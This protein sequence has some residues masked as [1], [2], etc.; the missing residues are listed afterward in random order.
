[1]NDDEIL[2]KHNFYKKEI[3]ESLEIVK[4]YI[5]NNKIYIT[6][7]MA[8]DLALRA[9]NTS[10]YNDFT[11]PDYD[12]ISDKNYEVS[13][14]LTEILCKL[15][16]PDVSMMPAIHPT[17]IK[18]KVCDYT[19]FDCTYLP[20]TLIQKIPTLK[21]NNMVIIHPTFIKIAQ[22]K[23]MS[24]LFSVT[25]EGYNIFY[26]LKKDYTRNALLNKHYP[27]KLLSKEIN[28][29]SYIHKL[30]LKLLES[31]NQSIK[32]YQKDKLLYASERFNDEQIIKYMK[33]QDSY[34]NTENSI[35]LGPYLSYLA[36]MKELHIKDNELIF[37]SYK[38]IAP[39]LIST[40]AEHI[41]K[42][43][44]LLNIKPDH[45]NK[46]GDFIPESSKYGDI[47]KVY[48]L[49][50]E[51]LSCNITRIND[52]NLLLCSPCYCLCIFLYYYMMKNDD[53]YLIM[54]N[55]MLSLLNSDLEQS[56]SLSTFGLSSYNEIEEFQIK[57][58]KN[59]TSPL[60]QP[61]RMFTS[62]PNCSNDKLFDYTTSYLY[63]IDGSLILS[64]ENNI[65]GGLS[66][67]NSVLPEY[68]KYSDNELIRFNSKERNW[69]S[70]NKD[71]HINTTKNHKDYP[72]KTNP[73]IEIYRKENYDKFKHGCIFGL[74][75]KYDI[76][77]KEK[78]NL[79][80]TW[81]W[82]QQISQ[83]EV[84]DPIIPYIIHSNNIDLIT[85]FEQYNIP[86]N[87]VVGLLDAMA[88][89]SLVVCKDLN[90]YV[91]DHIKDTK[92][93]IKA[94]HKG[95]YVS[96][97]YKNTDLMIN[98]EDF[99]KLKDWYDGN[100]FIMDL[101]CLLLRYEILGNTSVQAAL[102]T[103][104]FKL[105]N[106]ELNIKHECFASPLNAHNKTYCSAF[107]DTDKKFGS[108]GSFFDFYPKNGFY[109]ANP[110]FNEIIMQKMVEHIEYLL[111]NTSDALSF[112]II[113]PKWNDDASPMW[114]SLTNSRFNKQNFDIESDKHKYFKGDKFKTDKDLY[115]TAKHTT[116]I[117]ILSNI[118]QKKDIKQLLTESWTN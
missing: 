24:F 41:N 7:G 4:N 55:N 112:L 42:F 29:E 59:T 70:V 25:G 81:Y 56:F 23:S 28:K 26:R 105:L 66:Y 75:G 109:E 90:E 67:E 69:Y 19:I 114:Q 44:L 3:E 2:L 118:E 12:C 35:C 53:F 101:F 14:E 49:Y 15:G 103:K 31:T 77:V 73:D 71:I 96:L 72:K 5:I 27:I 102:P 62:Y 38:D 82:Y 78:R 40:N 8:I 33:H 110:P 64:Q 76:S 83:E 46:V 51:R 45:Y 34:F 57:K 10:I 111:I 80:E 6:G 113:V 63:K 1:M 52:N 50:G 39:T 107:I 106:K 93:K 117:F 16:Y 60:D 115:W 48:K 99:N 43:K 47:L 108:V 100:N 13:K 74:F 58:I 20:S 85:I 65:K 104:I 17:T 86:K 11:I 21:L 91:R 94:I 61:P 116:S 18:I 92:H 79:F 87:E 89:F 98:V 88:I 30:S 9:K 54:Y 22:Y 95:E 97:V 36:Y 32:I 68:L 84:L 37:T